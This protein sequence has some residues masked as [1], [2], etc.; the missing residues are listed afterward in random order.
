MF[1][2]F[3]SLKLWNSHILFQLYAI[4]SNENLFEEYKVSPLKW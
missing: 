1:D 3:V 4:K 2:F